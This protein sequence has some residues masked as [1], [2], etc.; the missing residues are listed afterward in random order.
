MWIFLGILAFIILLITVILLLPIY[1]IIKTD[2]DGEIIILYK[3]LHKT[4]GENP[5]PD[6]P[7]LKTLKKA[8]GVERLEKKNL[9]T[10]TE[11]SGLSDTVATSLNLI[12][13]LLKELLALLYYCTAKKFRL[14]IV[15]ADS[16]A[17]DAA[18]SYGSCC[19]I[20]YPILGYLHSVINI[21]KR[22]QD[23]S[24]DCIYEDGKDAFEFES[25]LVIRVFR[26][27]AALIRVSYAEALRISR[28][29]P[30]TNQKTPK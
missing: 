18:I 22:G 4:F 28:N 9:K 1:V 3:I 6:N 7:I 24:I 27:L 10:N 13:D 26:V 23:I 12:I 30:P 20:V 14:K 21:K 5:N 16:D 29:T 25:V 2:K 15:C 19:A 11:K 17:A 8:T